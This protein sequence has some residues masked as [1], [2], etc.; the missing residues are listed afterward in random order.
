MLQTPHKS[1][2]FLPMLKEITLCFL[3]GRDTQYLWYNIIE[4]KR[5]N[6]ENIVKGVN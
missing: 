1:V 2:D 3:S 5:K 4:Y 6:F